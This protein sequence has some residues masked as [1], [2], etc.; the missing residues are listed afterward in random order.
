MRSII[1]GVF[2]LLGTGNLYSQSYVSSYPK[3]VSQAKRFFTKHYAVL[4]SVCKKHNVDTDRTFAIVAPEVGMYSV[5]RD[6]METTATEL[7]YVEMGTS[8]NDFS[9]GYFQMKPSFAEAIESYVISLSLSEFT[10]LLPRNADEKEARLNRIARLKSLSYQAAYL[11]AF[12]TIWRTLHPQSTEVH[13]QAT[14]YNAGFWK[15][16]NQLTILASRKSFPRKVFGS[17]QFAY[18]EVAGEYYKSF[19]QKL[20]TEK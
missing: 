4:D 13:A 9:I 11:A 8:Y 2:L 1:A 17:K 6:R 10:N 16:E 19:S 3:E 5:W 20:N 14:A 7:F 15:D 18:G 12:I